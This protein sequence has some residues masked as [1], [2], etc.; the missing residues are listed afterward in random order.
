MCIIIKI[1]HLF[2]KHTKKLTDM[3]KICLLLY[4][5]G[6]F[7]FVMQIFKKSILKNEILFRVYS[8]YFQVT[9]ILRI[10]F[11]FVNNTIIFIGQVIV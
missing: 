3:E 6:R 9:A 8:N 4:C 11:M 5:G 1:I 2:Y 10:L 7:S